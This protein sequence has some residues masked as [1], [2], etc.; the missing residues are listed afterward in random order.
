M[1]DGGVLTI[2]TVMVSDVQGRGSDSLSDFVRLEIMDTGAGMTAETLDRI[3][4]PAFTTREDRWGLGLAM[5]RKVVEDH[6]G[7]V[8]VEPEQDIGNGVTVLLPVVDDER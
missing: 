8:V 7:R 1:I 4:E 2:R 6:G 5:V 3:F